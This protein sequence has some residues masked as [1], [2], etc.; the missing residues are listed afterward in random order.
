MPVQGMA[1]D[2]TTEIETGFSRQKGI[3]DKNV[4][5]HILQPCQNRI[6][7]GQT[8]HLE[9]FFAQYAL[10][11]SLRVRT[12]VRQQNAAHFV[13]GSGV[14]AGAL[15]G[16]AG[17]VLSAGCACWVVSGFF[18]FLSFFLA[19]TAWFVTAVSVAAGVAPV[20]AVVAVVP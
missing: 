20:V 11:H 1:L 5:I 9:A 10:T 16:S 17:L 14:G 2:M 13:V 12:V 7:V 3:R 4:G 18:F 19:T 8:D 15:A 6:S